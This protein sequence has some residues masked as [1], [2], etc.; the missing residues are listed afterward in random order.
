MRLNYKFKC[1]KCGNEM[2]T[3]LSDFNSE[4]ES[5]YIFSCNHCGGKGERTFPKDFESDKYSKSLKGRARL[6]FENYVLEKKSFRQTSKDTG[7]PI[8]NC[9]RILTKEIGIGARNLKQARK[10]YWRQKNETED[11]Q[12]N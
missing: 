4:E 6:V 3:T 12:D 9:Y 5:T 7:I 10:N 1:R 2:D 8:T 11:T